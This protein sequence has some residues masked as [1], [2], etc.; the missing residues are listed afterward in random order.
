MDRPSPQKIIKHAAPLASPRKGVVKRTPFGFVY[1][2]HSKERIDTPMPGNPHH[3]PPCR[4]ADEAGLRQRV[5]H[6]EPLVDDERAVVLEAVTDA[7]VDVAALWERWR[8]MAP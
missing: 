4:R 1:A 3:R 8:G 7:P 5:A 6:H 2:G